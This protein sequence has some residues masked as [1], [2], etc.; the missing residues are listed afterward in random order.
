MPGP[1]AAYSLTLLPLSFGEQCTVIE[2]LYP[3]AKQLPAK[4]FAALFSPGAPKAVEAPQEDILEALGE[5]SAGIAMILARLKETGPLHADSV[6]KE[7]EA[8]AELARSFAERK[9]YKEGFTRSQQ[10]AKKGDRE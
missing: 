5:L 4:A 1:W 6:G 2:T 8:M 7:R 10:K 3:E 9:A